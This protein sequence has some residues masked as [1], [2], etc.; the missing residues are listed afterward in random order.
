VVTTKANSVGE[1]HTEEE[2]LLPRILTEKG[3]ASGGGGKENLEVEDWNSKEVIKK[4]QIY[5]L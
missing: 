3:H 5:H 4:L 1:I 2:K